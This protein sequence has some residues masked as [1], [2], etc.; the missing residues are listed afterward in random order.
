MSDLHS[1]VTTHL[2]VPIVIAVTNRVPISMLTVILAF[3]IVK[4]HLS[5]V[6]DD[7]SD[8]TP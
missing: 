3:W 1:V 2:P 8:H 4:T 5:H 7:R 6:Q